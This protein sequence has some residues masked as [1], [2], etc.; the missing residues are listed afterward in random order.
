[1]NSSTGVDEYLSLTARGLRTCLETESENRGIEWD[2]YL[3]LLLAFFIMSLIFGPGWPIL[4]PLRAMGFG[5][6][7]V[8]AGKF[9]ES[10]SS[11]LSQ[12]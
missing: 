7:G 10:I 2:T 9:L 12:T 4:L 1:M 8:R 11:L 3:L 5:A 6:L